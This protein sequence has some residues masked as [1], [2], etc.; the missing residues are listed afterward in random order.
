MD[1]RVSTERQLLENRLGFSAAYMAVGFIRSKVETHPDAIDD[2]TAEALMALAG[3]DRFASKKQVLF[4]FQA[5]FDT[6][7]D[8]I[9][10]GCLPGAQS[11]IR[12]L[13]ALLVTSNG[14]RNRAISQALGR[15]PV[16]MKPAIPPASLDAL[17]LELRFSE[18]LAVFEPE[19]APV[20][21]WLGRS[22]HIGIG[23]NR[24]GIVKFAS[25][26]DNVRDLAMEAGWMHHLKNHP[27][28]PGIR[29][30]I[31]VPVRIRNTY[32]FRLRDLP[33]DI[34]DADHTTHHPVIAYETAP[35]YFHYP[36]S[37]DPPV[38]REIISESLFRSAR[39]LGTLAA[40]GTFHTAL[41]PLFH[42]RVQQGRRTDNGRYLWEHGGRLDQWLESCQYPNFARSGLRDFEHLEIHEN[43]RQLRHYIGEHLLSFILVIGSYFRNQQPLM[44]GTNADGTPC[45]T[46]HLFDPDFF[47]ELLAGV[48]RAYCRGLIG[49]V[50]A[51]LKRLPLRELIGLLIDKM[52]MDDDMGETLRIRDQEDMSDEAFIRFIRAR[53]FTDTASVERGRSDLFLTTGPHLGGFNQAISVP[54]LIEFLFSLSGLCVSDLYLV[55]DGSL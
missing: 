6:L 3:T 41:I 14:H 31:P 9:L 22:L 16:R 54:D 11:L 51:A 12:R 48:V 38:P 15:L 21:K 46:R 34:P 32:L 39:I 28:C 35:D 45:D 44:R 52:G 18:L 10:T 29:F 55:Q 30:Q 43:S 47:R 8:M 50:P 53:G 25:S 5:V 42:N 4:L 20:Y 7:V 2:Q 19:T 13:Q 1:S 33:A 40:A 37:W 36:N 49:R 26:R 23:K 27:P 17:P 24:L